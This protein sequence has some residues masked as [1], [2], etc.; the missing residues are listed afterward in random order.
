MAAIIDSVAPQATVTSVSGS[1]GRAHSADLRS[2]IAWRSAGAPQVVAYWWWAPPAVSAAWAART[3]SGGG[4]KSGKPCAKLIARSGPCRA[5]L[6][7]VISRM[8]DSVKLLALALSPPARRSAT[9][10]RPPTDRC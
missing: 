6:T 5:R 3:I 7:R 2:A 1:T 8:T 10:S 4:S 9:D